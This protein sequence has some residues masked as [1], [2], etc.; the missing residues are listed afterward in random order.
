MLLS[1]ARR[2]APT[3]R[4]AQAEFLAAPYKG[5]SGLKV[6]WRK[7]ETASCSRCKEAAKSERR[8]NNIK[9]RKE[10]SNK[11]NKCTDPFG[12]A[13]QQSLPAHKKQPCRECKEEQKRRAARAVVSSWSARAWHI[14]PKGS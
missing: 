9:A 2:P 3:R 8:A 11:C 6:G 1:V 7:K 4:E 14:I 12:T 13:V 10:P 5:E